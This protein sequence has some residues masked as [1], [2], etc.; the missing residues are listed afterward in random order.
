MFASR[1]DLTGQ[2][3]GRL[4]VEGYSHTNGARKAYWKCRCDCGGEIVAQSQKLRD[5]RALS[6]GCLR[7]QSPGSRRTVHG[8]VGTP[9]TSHGRLRRARC[10]N[11]N[12]D[13]YAEYGG[14]GITT[15][16][17]WKDSFAAFLDDMGERPEGKT[18]DRFPN[19]T[20]NYEPGN[21]RWATPLEQARNRK[22]P[23]KR[24][25]AA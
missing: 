21:C 3:F 6:C 14:A 25:V 7:G 5:G 17:R 23:R 19:R 24:K 15:C 18:L 20:G 2:H 9:T 8:G 1:I 11:P 4:T 16:D 13:H 22:W 12:S 10:F